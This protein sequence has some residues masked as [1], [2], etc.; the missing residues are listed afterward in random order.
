MEAEGRIAALE[1]KVAEL[2][3]ALVERDARLG[4]QDARIAELEKLL[5]AAHRSGKRQAAPF[6]KGEP[7]DEP[8][9]PGRKKGKGHG[10]HGHRMAPA[11]A[12]R[13]LDAPL[14]QRCPHCGDGLDF[15]RWADQHQTELPEMRPTV[16]RF[17]VGVGRCRGCKRRV[18]GR[19]REQTSDALGAAG[20]QVGPRAM[21]WATWLHYSLGLSFGK[22][23]TL[24]ARLG[25]N[26]T[27]GAIASSSASTGT[28]LVPTHS[29][30]V[31]HVGSAPA[32]VMD[33]TG[34]RIGGQGVWLWVA[35]TDDA[36]VY[37]VARGRGFDQ[38]T[39]LVPA[40]YT[41]VI[42]R[43]GW[44]VYNSYTKAS[45]QT[46]TAHILRRCHE[47]MEDLPTW[48]RGT[49]R[50]VRDLLLEALGARDLDAKGR[51]AAAVDIGERFDLLFEQAHPHDAN[52]R[53]V[54]HLRHERHA[55]LTFLT[56]D[57]V[58]AT[59]WRGEQ[60]VR[61]AVVNRK[62]WGGNRTDRGAE[63]QGRVMTFLRTAHQQGVDAI[64][65]LV[66]LARAPNPGIV[67]EL[68][69]RSA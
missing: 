42:V 2:L 45:H 68:T 41:G 29:A 25:V 17:R 67:G 63:T 55:L 22:C 49:P 15:E 4:E 35:A 61:P 66:D 40:A 11:D 39:G 6:S 51:A 13:V 36:T 56:T 47:M 46:C 30:I 44:I 1:T 33:E 20:A 31:T 59:N 27:A 48:A 57:G 65:L 23:S 14:P 52:R 7:S 26:V 16:T 43:D 18:Q 3:A 54:K 9:R 64:E 50:Q 69:L 10:R 37:D 60:A 19:H 34:W 62:V 58:D 5:E 32:V 28:D 38:A 8:A 53:L 21:A 12:D 24:L